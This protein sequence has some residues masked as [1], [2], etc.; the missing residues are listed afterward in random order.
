VGTY[1]GQSKALT[2]TSVTSVDLKIETYR[3]EAS[4]L[5]QQAK[6]L[7]AEAEQLMLASIEACDHPREA[8]VRGDSVA[9]VM[10]S[11][12]SPFLVCRR[13]GYAEEGW[14]AGTWRIK[15]NEWDSDIPRLDRDQAWRLVRCWVTQNDMERLGRY[16]AHRSDPKF[17]LREALRNL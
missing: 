7:R 3:A 17:N 5:L 14:G 11:A 12:F 8:L 16:G 10:G 1:G 9:Y 13:C 2:T 4:T 6:Q 15:A